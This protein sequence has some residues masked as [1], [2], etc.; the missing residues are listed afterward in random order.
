MFCVTYG[1]QVGRNPNVLVWSSSAQCSKDGAVLNK[2]KAI[3]A[4]LKGHERKVSL[5]FSTNW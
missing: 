2:K 3:V 5:R 4:T 1:L